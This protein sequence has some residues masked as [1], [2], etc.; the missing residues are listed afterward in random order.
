VSP[1]IAH[2]LV[3]WASEPFGQD[4][5]GPSEVIL[6]DAETQSRTVL[7][8]EVDPGNTMDDSGPKINDEVVVWAQTDDQG[9]VTLYVYDLGSSTITSDPD[10]VW[11][12]TCRVDGNLTVVTRHD[13]H[14]RELFLYNSDSRRNHQITDNGL[15]DRNP[16]ICGNR[17]AWMARGDIFL[18]EYKCLSLMQ[19][20][21]NGVL[22]R[23][24]APT[25]VWEGI[26]YPA[27]QVQ[28]SRDPDFS[29]RTTLTLP[30]LGTRWLSGTSFTPSSRQWR[31]ISWLDRR[32]GH[33][34]WRVKAKDADGNLGFSETRS[35]GLEKIGNT[36]PR[37][38]RR[39]TRP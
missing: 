23:M 25:F 38:S 33:L 28:F 22:P 12:D 37:G 27:C 32:D 11:K 3:V 1:Q 7:S 9:E 31:L 16:R 17:A 19:P 35:F 5:A 36:S 10:Y 24:P 2:G 8:E 26:G 30:A 6:Y 34:Y 4:F 15:Q 14:D 20:D 13:G 39:R 21:D 18:A 29:T